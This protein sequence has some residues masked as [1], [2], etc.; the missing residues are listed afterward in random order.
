MKKRKYRISDREVEVKRL[1]QGKEKGELE[2]KKSKDEKEVN[3]EV[4]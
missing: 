2:N 1:P 4:R 3:E